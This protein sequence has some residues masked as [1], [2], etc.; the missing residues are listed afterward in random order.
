MTRNDFELI[1]RAISEAAEQHRKHY[2]DRWP[3][4]GAEVVA[5][6]ADALAGVNARFDRARF[7]AACGLES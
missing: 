4:S 1:A 7:L 3:L 5:S 6:I 2:G